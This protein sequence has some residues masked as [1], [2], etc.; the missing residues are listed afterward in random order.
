MDYIQKSG[1]GKKLQKI[2]FR[3]DFVGLG[4]QAKLSGLNLTGLG[5]S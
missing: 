2:S 3:L 1:R 5:T 4:G